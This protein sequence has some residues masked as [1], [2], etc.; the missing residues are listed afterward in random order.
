MT[1]YQQ[2]M[3]KSIERKT[4][5]PLMSNY[6]GA[7][8]RAKSISVAVPKEI[9][10]KEEPSLEVTKK[11]SSAKHEERN[12]QH[13]YTIANSNQRYTQQVNQG[14]SEIMMNSAQKTKPGASFKRTKSVDPNSSIGSGNDIQKKEPTYI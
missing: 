3:K 6:S 12:P 5:A 8:N 14:V 4:M 7:A 2:Q 10:T 1:S 11:Q 13:S 9:L